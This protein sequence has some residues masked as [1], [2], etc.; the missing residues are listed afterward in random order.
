MGGLLTKEKMEREELET[1]GLRGKSSGRK[2]SDER[3]LGVEG[4]D[5]SAS[6]GR[7]STDK[8]FRLGCLMRCSEVSSMMLMV[9]RSIVL[10]AFS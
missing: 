2:G 6:I 1:R 4:R 9:D 8:V 7:V 10:L 3:E 5:K